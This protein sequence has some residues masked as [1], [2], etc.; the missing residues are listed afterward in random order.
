MLFKIKKFMLP[1]M[2]SISKH[3]PYDLFIEEIFNNTF[4]VF[5]KDDIWGVRKVCIENLAN[6]V[7][8]LKADDLQ[9]IEDCIKFFQRCLCD[10]NRWVK[11]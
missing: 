2:I 3:L 4:A 9:R 8:Y 6:L 7:K 10:Q 11:N 5:N 1:A